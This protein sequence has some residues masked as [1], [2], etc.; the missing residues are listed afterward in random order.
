MSRLEQ[1]M[2]GAEKYDK[3]CDLQD[4]VNPQ[5]VERISSFR[6]IPESMFGSVSFVFLRGVSL[7]CHVFVFHV[8]M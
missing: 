6:D 7:R 1:R 4:S 3:H 5:K 8:S 2:K